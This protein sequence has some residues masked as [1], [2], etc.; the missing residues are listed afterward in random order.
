MSLMDIAFELADRMGRSFLIQAD[1]TF[2]ILDLKGYRGR[3]NY[4]EDSVQS[5]LLLV[6]ADSLEFL[7]AVYKERRYRYLLSL[8]FHP[9]LLQL[10]DRFLDYART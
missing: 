10:E 5:M 4:M 9:L 3:K 8:R 2:G 7:E 1:T 6:I